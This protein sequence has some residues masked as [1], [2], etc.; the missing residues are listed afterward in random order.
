MRKINYLWSVFLIVLTISLNSCMSELDKYYQTPDWLKGNSWEVLEKKGN[1]KM[2]L[3]A[4]ER[5][6][7]KDLVQGKGIIT[8][9]APT[10][11]AFQVYL[12]R[13]GY[14]S[15][16]DIP[17]ET[18]NTLIGYHLVFYSFDKE[19]FENYNPWGK[20]TEVKVKGLYFKFRTKSRDD[21][22]IEIDPT[23][24]NIQRKVMH[25]D[26]FLP[27]FSYNF[28]TGYGLDAKQNYEFFYPNSVWTGADGFNV[29]NASVKEYAI[30]SDNG[31]VYVVNQVIEPLETIYTTLSK[32]NGFDIFKKAFNRF[33]TF[34]YDATATS[35]YGNGDS[36]YIMYH[37]SQLPPIASE[38]TSDLGT[39][40]EYA[41]LSLLSSRAYNLFAADDASMQAFFSKYWASYYNSIDS[42]KFEP[43]LALLQNHVYNGQILF[44]EQIE[45]G[46]FKTSYGNSIQ[47]NRSSAKLKSICVNG[48]LYGLDH[49]MIPPMFEKVTAPMYC[50]PDYTIFL[51][52]VKNAGYIQTLITN[53]TSFKIF[54]PKDAMITQNTNLE[55]REIQ[56]QN[57]NSKKY[58]SQEVQINTD[59][60]FAA[61]SIS[62]KK[63]FAG[64]HIATEMIA[65][66]GDEHIYRTLLPYNYIY[67]KGNKVY[68]SALFNLGVDAKVP[69]FSEISGDWNNGIAYSL[70]GD[71]ASALVPEYN[72]FK[73]MITS[74]AS[75]TVFT[76][77][78]YTVQAAGMDKTSP[79]FDFLMG[80]KFIAFIPKDDAIMTGWTNGKVPFSPATTVSSYLKRY[81]V[82]V[83]LSNLL[84]YPFSGAGIEGELTTF[85]KNA[86][87]NVVK[88]TLIDRAGQ[89][90]VKDAKGT[91]VKVLSF[92]P[93]IYADGAAYLIDGLLEIE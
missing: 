50:N 9:M 61:M 65:S 7:Y 38:W 10:D 83:S 80:E 26:R 77:F 66:K 5:T 22:S 23:A 90:Y 6:S 55:G 63:T 58:G 93:Y 60:G 48:T 91:E 87:G 18:L 69:T 1:F 11:S 20:E 72:Q 73:S 32:S 68:S 67:T 49:V 29:S 47:F 12:T 74:V 59:L 21:I 34:E 78:K 82:N 40:N 44:P 57:I 56:Y 19:T 33:V 17:T 27:V 75:P 31:Y 84:D 54:Y 30:V 81:F 3:A 62:Q 64:S 8:V 79:P 13:H 2:F 4:V 53:A 85:A 36:L 45:T 25:K 88:Y 41:Q 51:D 37:G 39:S 92:F 28:F 15:V 70:S 52:I 42:V 16:E 43:L 76:N 46:L 14:S 24:N 35:E 86:E 71:A 89:L